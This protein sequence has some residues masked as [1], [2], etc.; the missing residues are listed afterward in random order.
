MTESEWLACADPRPMLGF[1]R[2]KASD[3]QLRLF[4]CAN[5]RAVRATEHL[6]PGAA[7]AVAERYA[8]GLASDQDL[9]FERRGVPFPDSYSE[10]VLAQSAYDGAWQP[11]DWLTSARD[12]MKI[13]PDALRHFP[14]PLDDVVQRAVHLLRD[15]FGSL[16]FRPV[17]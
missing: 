1:L 11:V 3:R 10:W 4:A 12:L 7:V 17:T 2:G 9:E 13:D 14:F 5:S 6:G 8:D 15:I 16:P